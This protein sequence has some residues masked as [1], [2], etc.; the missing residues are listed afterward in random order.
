[1]HNLF[2]HNIAMTLTQLLHATLLVQNLAKAQQFYEGLL[3]LTSVERSLSFEGRWYQIGA[4]QI[5]LIVSAQVIDDL[6]QPDKWGRNRHLAFAIT[7]LD[8]MKQ[9]LQAACYPYQLSSSGRAA[10][11]VRDPD[12][13]LIELQQCPVEVPNES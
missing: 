2:L 1:L 8:A 6:V 10:L 5:H 9:T 4:V 13:N 11:F 7:D 12:G 3:G